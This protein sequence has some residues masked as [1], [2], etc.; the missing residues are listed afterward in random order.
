MP[1]RNQSWKPAHIHQNKNR[2]RLK[3]GKKYEK[4]FAHCKLLKKKE[5]RDGMNPWLIDAWKKVSIK[6]KKYGITQSMVDA[7]LQA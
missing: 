2:K 1:T 4:L 5:Q 6:M 7:Y 3:S